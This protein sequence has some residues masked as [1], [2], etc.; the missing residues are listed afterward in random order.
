MHAQT[1]KCTIWAAQRLRSQIYIYIYP[2]LISVEILVKV[3]SGTELLVGKGTVLYGLGADFFLPHCL[4]RGGQVSEIR[5]QLGTI[6]SWYKPSAGR[7]PGVHRQW[8]KA[9]LKL[10]ALVCACAD[11]SWLQNIPCGRH[12]GYISKSN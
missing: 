7:N 4:V 5:K 11:V 3:V 9:Q 6:S 12:S 2:L 1:S 8:Y 10:L